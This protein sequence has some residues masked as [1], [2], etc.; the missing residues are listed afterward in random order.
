M[1]VLSSPLTLENGTVWTVQLSVHL[2]TCFS[3]LYKRLV[4]VTCL[5]FGVINLSVPRIVFLC[6]VVT[7]LNNVPWAM[8]VYA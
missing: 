1:L 4:L 6:D 3:R 8:Y 7:P 2:L 5:I